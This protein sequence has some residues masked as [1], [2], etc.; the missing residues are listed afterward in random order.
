MH[1]GRMK[2]AIDFAHFMI[3]KGQKKNQ[4]IW[5]SSNYHKIDFDSLKSKVYENESM[6]VGE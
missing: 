4:A 2:K 3:K 6:M 1:E 5:I